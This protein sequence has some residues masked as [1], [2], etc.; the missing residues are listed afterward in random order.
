MYYLRLWGIKEAQDK[1]THVTQ[2]SEQDSH[3]QVAFSEC[4]VQIV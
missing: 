1:T 2:D 4:L 3:L